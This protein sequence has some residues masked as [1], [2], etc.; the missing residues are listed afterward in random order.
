[1]VRVLGTGAIVAGGAVVDAFDRADGVA[2]HVDPII[3]TSVTT[4][5]IKGRRIDVTV[6]VSPTASRISSE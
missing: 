2:A 4:D 3:N 5:T 6:P 1:M